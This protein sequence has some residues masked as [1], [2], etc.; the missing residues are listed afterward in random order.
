MRTKK[1]E[2]K[3]DDRCQVVCKKTCKWCVHVYKRRSSPFP[4][5]IA[6]L[7]LKNPFKT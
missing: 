7:I 2:E 5:K 3:M 1:S 4:L 6:I